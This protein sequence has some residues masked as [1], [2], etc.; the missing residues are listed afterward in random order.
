MKKM[1]SGPWFGSLL[2][3]VLSSGCQ[4]IEEPYRHFDVYVKDLHD[5]L[6]VPD[7]FPHD[8]TD[9]YEQH[10]IDTN[11]VSMRFNLNV[12]KIDMSIFTTVPQSE[13]TKT[14]PFNAS[15]WFDELPSHYKFYKG[16]SG[17]S[18]SVLAHSTESTVV[19]WWCP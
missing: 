19:Y 1:T 9:I 12:Q 11:E 10:D 16:S 14:K 4:L 17:S 18:G 8:I 6:W 13:V 2:L 7:I 15:W 3:V 5:G